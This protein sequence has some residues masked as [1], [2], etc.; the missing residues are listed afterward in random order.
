M[1]EPLLDCSFAGSKLAHSIIENKLAACV[2]QIPG[3]FPSNSYIRFSRIF[4]TLHT[5]F[6]VHSARELKVDAS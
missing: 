5:E 3:P 1:F 6:Q 4:C 2:N